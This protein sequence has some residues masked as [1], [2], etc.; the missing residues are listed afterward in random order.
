VFSTPSSLHVGED[1]RDDPFLHGRRPCDLRRDAREYAEKALLR[2][3]GQ[4]DGADL[5]VGR[6]FLLAEALPK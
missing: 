3:D 6:S 2:A 4:P 1:H 5:G